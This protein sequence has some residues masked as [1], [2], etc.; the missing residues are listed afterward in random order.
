MSYRH[1]HS[2]KRSLLDIFLFPYAIFK[3][4]AQRFMSI[5]VFCQT[6]LTIYLS[7][8]GEIR[9]HDPLLARQVLSQLSYTPMGIS[10]SISLQVI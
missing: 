8:D 3:V 9:T 7:G 1:E 4:H 5:A 2:F 6:D 10:Y